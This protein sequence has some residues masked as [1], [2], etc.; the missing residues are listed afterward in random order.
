MGKKM[1]GLNKNQNIQITVV[2]SGTAIPAPDH[3]PASVLLQS[4][5]FTALM[6]IGPGTIS[7]LPQYGLDAFELENIFISHL[8]P[9]HTL[10]LV[11]FFMICDFASGKRADIPI[12]LIGCE[13]LEEF[14][15]QLMAVFPDIDLPSFGMNITEVN[16]EKIAVDGVR[17]STVLSGHTETSVSFRLDFKN[18][19]IVYTGDCVRNT[20]LTALCD[21]ADLLI[22]ECSFP[23]DQVTE[24]HMN[25]QTL[26]EMAEIAKVKQLL[27]T[28]QYPPALKVNLAEQIK[29]YYSGPVSIALDGT[30]IILD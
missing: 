27:V 7:K 8:H 30:R 12:N 4:L 10:D 11:T 16:E 19:S 23:E 1:I 3:S 15:N 20:R 17:I 14:I 13:G 22:S 26:G 18:S 2:G 9:D 25:A 29:K 6:D 21:K 28:H 24:D 5:D